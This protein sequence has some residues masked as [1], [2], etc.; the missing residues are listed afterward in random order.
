ME[1]EVLLRPVPVLKMEFWNTAVMGV[2]FL[3]A[4]PVT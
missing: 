3:D 1:K 4:A 2:E